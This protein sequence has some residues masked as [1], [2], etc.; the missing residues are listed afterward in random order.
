VR[1][2]QNCQCSLGR[3]ECRSEQSESEPDQRDLSFKLP[4]ISD[5]TNFKRRTSMVRTTQATRGP[6]P[7]LTG[8]LSQAT[9]LCNVRG[10]WL[11]H[12]DY[13]VVTL[14]SPSAVVLLSDSDSPNQNRAAT[15]SDRT[16]SPCSAR[17]R[18]AMSRSRPAKN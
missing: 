4:S 16:R 11:H 5:S 15:V 13:D 10:R 9:D 3:F 12:H 6:G 14:S 1:R 8:S 18:S 7:A 17:D 2:T